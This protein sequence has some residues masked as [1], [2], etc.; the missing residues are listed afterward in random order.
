[1]EERYFLMNKVG[2]DWVVEGNIHGYTTFDEINEFSKIYVN[3]ADM[4]YN[5]VIM[6]AVPFA[7]YNNVSGS[8]TP[9]DIDLFDTFPHV[10]NYDIN[11]VLFVDDDG[12]GLFSELNAKYENG[13]YLDRLKQ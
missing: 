2:N 10:Y 8:F 12:N 7:K 6:K 11:N 4:K 13:D 5:V 3:A 1:M 9:V